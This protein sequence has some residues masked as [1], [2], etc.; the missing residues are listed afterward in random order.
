MAYIKR[1]KLIRPNYHCRDLL[2]RIIIQNVRIEPLTYV[3]YAHIN[4]PIQIHVH[5]N[6]KHYLHRHIVNI[7]VA[8]LRCSLKCGP[9]GK[10]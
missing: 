5:A 7:V 3:H 6:K 1:T 10:M 2:R 8:Q 9:A 4:I